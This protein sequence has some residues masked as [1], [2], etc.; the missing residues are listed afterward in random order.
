VLETDASACASARRVPGVC[1]RPMVSPILVLSH[2]SQGLMSTKDKR[3]K[4]SW[5]PSSG[6]DIPLLIDTCRHSRPADIHSSPH[7]NLAYT[8]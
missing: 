2:P 1:R 7:D 4:P 6:R 8:K 5:I 3:S